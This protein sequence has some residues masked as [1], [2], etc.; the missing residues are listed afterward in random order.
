[1]KQYVDSTESYII[2][3]RKSNL[4]KAKTLFDRKLMVKE[5]IRL[6]KEQERYKGVFVCMVFVVILVIITHLYQMNRKS[7]RIIQQEQDLQEKIEAQH[8][9]QKEIQELNEQ[10]KQ[11]R[12]DEQE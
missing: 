12:Q 7:R 4:D 10:L 11:K 6:Y 3:L 9:L 2:G 1:M 5:N 8:S